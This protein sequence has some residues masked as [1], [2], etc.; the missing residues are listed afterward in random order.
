MSKRV[1]LLDIADIKFCIVNSSKKAASA[2]KWI[3]A[4]NLLCDNVVTGV[5]EDNKARPD[6]SLRVYENDIIIKRISPSY[7]NLINIRLNDIYAYNNLI[8]VRAK[9]VEAKYLAYY[10]SRKIKEFSENTSVGAVMPSIGRPELESFKIPILPINK[11]KA[12]GELWYQSIEKK[13]M[14]LQLAKLENEKELYL[15]NKYVDKKVGG[16]KHDNL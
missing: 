3:M 16:S 2:S 11:Q 9:A 8:I 1:S 7:I 15:L 14:L 10:L 12:V 13:K 5:F 6:E 4:A